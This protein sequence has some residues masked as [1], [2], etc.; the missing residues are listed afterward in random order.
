MSPVRRLDRINIANQVG[1]C[2]VGRCQFFT[3]ALITMNPVNRRGI[4][5]LIHKV[6][7]KLANRVERIVVDFT[8]PNNRDVLIKQ[9]R[10]C[11]HNPRFRLAAKTK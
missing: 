8:P 3:V 11:A 6:N 10:E 9:T 1:D 2:H 4:A 7:C 5:M